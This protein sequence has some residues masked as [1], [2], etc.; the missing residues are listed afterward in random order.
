MFHLPRL[1]PFPYPIHIYAGTH[2]GGASTGRGGDL[3]EEEME[4]A[5]SALADPNVRRCCVC[6]GW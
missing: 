5:A 3:H 1:E 2:T 6:C 4:P